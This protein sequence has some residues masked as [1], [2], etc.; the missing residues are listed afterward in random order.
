MPINAPPFS[1]CSSSAHKCVQATC[2]IRDQRADAAHIASQ[3]T[4]LGIFAGKAGVLEA[5]PVA[6]CKGAYK[7]SDFRLQKTEDRDRDRVTETEPRAA[8]THTAKAKAEGWLGRVTPRI[9]L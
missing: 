4:A 7:T 9:C 8:H 5:D 3:K 1:P 6:T 2:E